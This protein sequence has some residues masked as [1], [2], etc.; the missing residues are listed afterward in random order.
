MDGMLIRAANEQP[1]DT[2]G[3]MAAPATPDGAN[4][5]L[6]VDERCFCSGKPGRSAAWDRPTVVGERHA[7]PVQAPI[8]HFHSSDN[9]LPSST[10]SA[11][12]PP[13]PLAGRAGDAAVYVEL[14]PVPAV[15]PYDCAWVL[16]GRVPIVRPPR[17]SA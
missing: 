15:R 16:H 14:E 7:V 13:P 17:T 5:L 6:D 4:A 2:A 3:R 1:A 8:S 9:P 10:P 11:L 12:P